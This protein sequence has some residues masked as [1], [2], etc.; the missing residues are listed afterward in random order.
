VLARLPSLLS[1]EDIADDLGV[2]VN[3]VKTHLR[4]I[5]AKLGVTGRRAAVF[6]A[7]DHKV[8]V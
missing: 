7:H 1:L 3:T 6:A 2:S 4:S 8:L 5:Y